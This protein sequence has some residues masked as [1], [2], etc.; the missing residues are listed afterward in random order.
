MNN[1]LINNKNKYDS[2]YNES[3]NNP[4]KFWND[5]ASENFSWYDKWSSVV[6]WDFHKAKINWFSNAKLNITVNCIDRHVKTHPDKIAI[7]FE[8]NNVNEKPKSF[9]Y[10]ELLVEV[11]KM[12]NVLKSLG[13]KK[14]D[15]VCIYLPMIPELAFSVLACARI[16]AIHSVVF[17]GFSSDALA[18]RIND[19]N[20]SLTITSDGSFRGAKTL[21]LKNIVDD[22]LLKCNDEQKVLVV[23]RTLEPIKMISKRDVFLEDII[24]GVDDYCKPEIMDAEDPLF[25]L[26]TSGSTGKP[27]GMVHTTA[28]YMV[29]TSYTFKNI[30]QY[31]DND[32]YWCTADIGWITGHSYILYGPLSNG[33]TTLMFEGVPSYPDFSRF[34]SIVEKYKVTQFYTAPT[35]IRA[36]AKQGVKFVQGI[37][38]S[39]LKVLGTVGEPINE[40]AW[41]WYNTNIGKNNCPIVDTWWQTETGGILISSIPN[42]IPDKP[43]FATK[44][45]LGVQPMLVDDNGNELKDNNIVGKL[46]INFPWPSIARTIWGNHERYINT[47]FS[48][49]KGKYF[50]GDGAYRDEYGNY[51]ITGRVDDVVI[52]SGHNL[53]TAPIEDAINEHPNIAESAIVGFPHEI[54]GNALYGFITL[55]DSSIDSNFIKSDINKIISDKIG[56]IAKLDKIQITAGLPKTRSGKIMRR[57][58][59]KIASGDFNNLGD[60]STLL[61]PEV[62]DKII[63]NSL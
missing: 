9:T 17:A 54:K 13:V 61:N 33:A 53:G 56:P 5:I 7:L 11:S 38:L 24:S 50:T 30:F 40:E 48:T 16:G 46:C 22:A 59:R 43:T 3:L 15:R 35:A 27:K 36:L 41:N 19:C 4:E 52:V 60:I 31:T 2:A 29:Y 28:G 39:S 8:P 42:V 55:K 1:Y 47:Y 34:W 18:T 12:A 57:I 49:F 20:S 23:K 10:S 63:N 45:F 37:D 32:V 21:N 14:G 26:Y 62:V 58:L 44:P 51:R 25:I 6:E